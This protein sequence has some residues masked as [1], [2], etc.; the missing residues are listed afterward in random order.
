MASWVRLVDQLK[1]LPKEAE[2]FP[3]LNLSDLPKFSEETHSVESVFEFEQ[4]DDAPE[5]RGQ[6]YFSVKTGE[7]LTIYTQNEERPLIG[8]VVKVYPESKE[9]D[10]H[11]LARVGKSNRFLLEFLDNE[12]RIDR[13]EEDTVMFSNMR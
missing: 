7:D 4:E 2:S 3:R 1:N 9:F 10:I 8:R 13:L 5:L 6:A 11:W 12:A